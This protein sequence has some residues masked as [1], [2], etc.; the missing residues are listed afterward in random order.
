[1]IIN[2]SM[3]E[4]K[5]DKKQ[6]K[7]KMFLWGTG[8]VAQRIFEQCQI[9]NIYD[10][11]GFIDNDVDREGHMFNGLKIYPP[12]ILSSIVPEK[13]VILAD[14]YEEI[15]AQI[16]K[17]YPELE[18]LIENKY[19]FYKETIFRRYAEDKNE[20]IIEVL[21]YI[22]ENGLNIFNYK[23]TE[24]YKKLNVNV[25]FDATNEMFYV[26]HF[27][28]RMYFPRDW[29]NKERITEYYRNILME[30]D[31]FSPHRYLTIDFQVED[32]DVVVDVGAAEGNFSLEI[33]D[34]VSKIYIIESDEKWIEALKE[35]FRPYSEK[36]IFINKFITSYNEGE[37]AT[38]DSLI[39]DSV[40]FIKMDIEGNEWEALCGAERLIKKSTKL[41]CTICSYH[42]DVD[43]ILIKDVLK[44]NEFE[45]MTTPGFMW[46]PGLARQSYI[47]TKLNRAIVKGI[48]MVDE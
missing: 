29:K 12:S 45:Y 42:R 46:Y 9:V 3:T 47:S 13:I 41:K 36:V 37:F 15:C 5:M 30:Q 6:K 18:L 33:I 17:N 4:C 32:N 2:E 35:T 16:R 23:F 22:K 24:K 7:Y 26:L 8:R 11:L 21:N 43:E 28:K 31:A 20:E 27:G 14:A 25:F 48:R 38:L 19:F 39:G 44:K 40:N 10:V 1:M 34:R